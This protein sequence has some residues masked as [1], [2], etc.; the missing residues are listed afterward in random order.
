MAVALDPEAVRERAYALWDARGRPEGSPDADWYEAEAQL[1][2][3]LS[4][5]GSPAGPLAGRAR[6]ALDSESDV[7]REQ[8]RRRGR[9]SSGRRSPHVAL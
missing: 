9:G 2:N 8:P 7:G 5:A 1:Q 3:E 6:R 4:V